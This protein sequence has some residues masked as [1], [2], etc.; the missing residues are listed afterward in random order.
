MIRDAIQDNEE[1]RTLGHPGRKGALSGNIGRLPAGLQNRYITLLS[2]ILHPQRP[3]INRQL[4]AM[5]STTAKVAKECKQ[6]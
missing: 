6:P 1:P 3:F 4:L 2:L 5:V